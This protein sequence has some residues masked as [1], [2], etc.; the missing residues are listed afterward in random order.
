ME[1]TTAETT[2]FDLSSTYPVTAVQASR[3]R[4]EGH[5]FLPGVAAP[6]EVAWYRPFIMSFFEDAARTLDAHTR[7]NDP[8]SLYREVSNL[9]RRS[10]T[11]RGLV[12][13]KRFA[14]LAAELMGVRA[15]RL[16]HDQAHVKEPGGPP[17]PW[18]KDHFFWP[19]ATHHTVKMSLALCDISTTMGA[20]VFASGSNHGRLFP[21]VPFAKNLQEVFTWVIRN[22]GIPTPSYPMSAG[23]ATFHSGDTLHSALENS[24]TRRRE[25]LTI[26]YYAD[27]TRIMVPDHAHRWA[28]LK[29]FLPGLNPGDFAASEL[30]PVLYQEGS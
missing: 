9:W 22:H 28:D 25:V 17:T 30:N 19:L 29:E 15:V 27:E 2:T 1:T 8:A 5:I 6:E 7:R 13:A 23:D 24:T 3:Y 20:L 11:V 10:E 21:E 18:H 14:R 26:I 4:K 12:F 16:F